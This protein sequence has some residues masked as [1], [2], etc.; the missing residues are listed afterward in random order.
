MSLWATIRF[1]A[2]AELACFISLAAETGIGGGVGLE[3]TNSPR[4]RSAGTQAPSGVFLTGVSCFN[5]PRW[6]I[7]SN[8][9]LEIGPTFYPTPY[10]TIVTP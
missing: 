2:V 9:E 8:S 6:A 4:T 10:T 1:D 7:S 3:T 5:I